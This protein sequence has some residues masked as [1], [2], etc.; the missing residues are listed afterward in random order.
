ML[1]VYAFA[2]PNSIKVPIML[3]ELELDYQL[4]PIYVRQGEQKSHDFLQL[5][6]NGKVP[7]LVESNHTTEPLIP[8]IRRFRG[9]CGLLHIILEMKESISE[10]EL[11]RKL[12][13]VG[14]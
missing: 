8:R 11:R 1:T 7:V 5:N 3:E 14:S 13:V 12:M 10:I 9:S 2:T 6:A 4:K